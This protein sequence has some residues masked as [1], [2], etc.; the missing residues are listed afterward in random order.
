MFV[1]IDV[2]PGV[3]GIPVT[4]YRSKEEVEMVSA[5]VMRVG[6]GGRASKSNC[7]A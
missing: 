5:S 4:A 1:I 6:G 3:E 2:R 7:L